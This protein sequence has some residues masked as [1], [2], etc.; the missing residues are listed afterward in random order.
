MQVHLRCAGVLQ[1]AAFA[2]DERAARKLAA[3]SLKRSSAA[4]IST[5]FQTITRVTT[6]IG[7]VIDQVDRT[8]LAM[9]PVERTSPVTLSTE[10]ATPCR[11]RRGPLRRSRVSPMVQACRRRYRSADRF[12][13]QY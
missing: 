3:R 12:G 7:V 1:P 6:R 10:L 9:P 11:R 13:A 4:S 8:A 2:N 5:F